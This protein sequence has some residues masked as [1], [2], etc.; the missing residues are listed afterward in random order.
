VTGCDIDP[1]ALRAARRNLE[2]LFMDEE[3]G[4]CEP[5]FSLVRCDVTGLGMPGAARKSDGKR[6]KNGGGKGKGPCDGRNNNQRRGAVPRGR[7]S[8]GRKSSE[9]GSDDDDDSDKDSGDESSPSPSS[10]SESESS[11]ESSSAAERRARATDVLPGGGFPF[12]DDS[13]DTV[14]MNPPFGTRRG[15]GADVAFLQ[16]AVLAA[17]G[18][19]YSLHKSSTRDVG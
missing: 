17:S 13:F 7:R 15:G 4:V 16:A 12:R 3:T 5:G 8:S 6:G 1:S 2:D 9:S 19:V 11:S 10:E 14:V 18:A